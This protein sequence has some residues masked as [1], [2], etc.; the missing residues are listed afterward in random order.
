MFYILPI[1]SGDLRQIAVRQSEYSI[2]ISYLTK[3]KL[4]SL[5]SGCF[6]CCLMSLSWRKSERQA[7]QQSH[8]SV[9]R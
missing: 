4:F 3:L 9:S 1:M 6:I 7:I 8:A 2:S 5:C